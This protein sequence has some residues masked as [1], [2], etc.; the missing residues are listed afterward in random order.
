MAYPYYPQ[1]PQQTYG[2][3]P[4]YQNMMSQAPQQ[5]MPA[6]QVP[7]PQPQSQSQYPSSDNIVWVQGEVGALAYPQPAP[8][9]S[10]LLMDSEDSR[11]F[12]KSTD[13]YGRPLPLRKFRFGEE[14]EESGPKNLL[15]TNGNSGRAPTIDTS[16]FVTR[17][18]MDKKIQEK[19]EEIMR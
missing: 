14:T 8:G 2:I 5:P 17:E 11:F 10:V 7:Q 9:H 16:N 3:I 12:I 4:Q 1:V 19:I 18:E 13:Q 6:P 15:Q